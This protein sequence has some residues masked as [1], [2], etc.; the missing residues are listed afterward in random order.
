MKKVKLTKLIASTLITISILSLNPVKANAEWKQD[1]KNNYIKWWYSEGNSYSIGWKE[2]DGKWYY[3]DTSGYMVKDKVIDGYYID[4]NGHYVPNINEAVG[5]YIDFREGI[6]K[7]YFLDLV[8]GEAY[9]HDEAFR[10]PVLK[11]DFTSDLLFL[12]EKIAAG[13][14]QPDA[15][16]EASNVNNISEFLKGLNTKD[17]KSVLQLEMFIMDKFKGKKDENGKYI[18][19]HK[20]FLSNIIGRQV[21]DNTFNERLSLKERALLLKKVYEFSNANKALGNQLLDYLKVPD[22]TDI[23]ST[24]VN[25]PIAGISMADE[26]FSDGSYRTGMDAGIVNGKHP[27]VMVTYYNKSIRTTAIATN[28]EDMELSD[29]HAANI[30]KMFYTYVQNKY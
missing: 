13:E 3:F 18:W 26:K 23:I 30:A 16:D 6:F 7:Y 8:T 19:P 27:F 24:T 2:I 20:Q 5:R 28:R 21:E 12:Y 25:A 22:S 15:K 9:G 4:M 29:K 11:D 17:D 10:Y 14:I 1:I